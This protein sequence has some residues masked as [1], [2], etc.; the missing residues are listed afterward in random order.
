MPE[1]SPEI[2]EDVPLAIYNEIYFQME[3]AR[4]HNFQKL[5]FGGKISTA[6]VWNVWTSAKARKIAWP[7]YVRFFCG[8]TITRTLQTTFL[9]IEE[10]P[11]FLINVQRRIRKIMRKMS[12]LE[13]DGNSLSIV[14]FVFCSLY[15]SSFRVT[16]I[17]C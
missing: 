17:I 5:A 3:G 4:V 8:D 12:G 1:I 6:L 13:A 16:I 7:I 11:I 10:R 15:L 2:L 14:F 9:Q